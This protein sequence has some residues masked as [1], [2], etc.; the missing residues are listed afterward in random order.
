[1]KKAT[2]DEMK[3]HIDEI[4]EKIIGQEKTILHTSWSFDNVWRSRLN[5]NQIWICVENGSCTQGYHIFGRFLSCI[6]AMVN[7]EN[8][9]QSFSIGIM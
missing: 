5:V 9:V 4:K 8:Y 6:R 2:L 3:K 7:I 1:M